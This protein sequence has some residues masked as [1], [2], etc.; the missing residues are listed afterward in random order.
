MANSKKTS[1]YKII[2]E[3]VDNGYTIRLDNMNCIS[4]IFVTLEEV[5]KYV[6]ETFGVK[7]HAIEYT[8]TYND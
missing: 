6:Q 4:K 3:K 1:T 7:E 5:T 2:I 8:G